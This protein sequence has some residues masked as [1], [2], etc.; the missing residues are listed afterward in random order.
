M[1]RREFIA[2]IGGAVAWPLVARAQQPPVPVVGIL[3]GQSP[4]TY[5]PFVAAIGDGLRETGYVE[6]QNVA[7]EYRWAEGQYSRLPGLAADLV[8]HRVAVIVAG[9]SSGNLATTAARAATT[10][11]PIV[12][13]SGDDPVAAGLVAQLNRPGGNVTGVTF[14]SGELGPKRLELLLELSPRVTAIGLLANPINR[15]YRP[16]VEE[17][18]KAAQ[19]HG[20]QLIVVTAN[21]E[22]SGVESEFEGAFAKLVQQSVNALV[23]TPDGFFNAQR[24]R[25]VA[26]AARHKIPSIYEGRDAAVAGGLIAYG[27]SPTGAYRQ[28]GISAGKILQGANPGE[29]PVQRP[30]KFELVINIKTAKALGLTVPQTLLVAADEVIE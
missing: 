19:A 12:F 15:Y 22:N 2:L 17:M 27:A 20:R 26:L 24:N 29:L 21:P 11:I 3:N 9:G 5:R 7:I 28:A 13:T 23:V 6:G 4:E 1:R 18:Q 16:Y 25:I 30:T 8:N 14:F 10:T